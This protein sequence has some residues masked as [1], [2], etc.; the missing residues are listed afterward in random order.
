VAWDL[1]LGNR[2]DFNSSSDSQITP[3][4]LAM[5]FL[6]PQNGFLETEKYNSASRTTNHLQPYIEDE[7]RR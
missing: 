2:F 3:T 6:L 7:T 1:G 5:T 4:S